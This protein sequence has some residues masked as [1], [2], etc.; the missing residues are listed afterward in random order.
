M[1]ETLQRSSQKRCYLY[2]ELIYQSSPHRIWFQ[3]LGR[4]DRRS[5]VVMC[6]MRFNYHNLAASLFRKNWCASPACPCGF[7]SEDLNHIFWACRRFDQPRQSLF[8]YLFSR[9]I[10]SPYNIESF[11]ASPSFRTAFD[12][13]NEFSQSLQSFHSTFNPLLTM[14][15]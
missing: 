11:L 9:K 14:A 8:K 12:S 4:L 5:I 1:P 3:D 2:F 7:E 10:C 13:F 15:F 6:R